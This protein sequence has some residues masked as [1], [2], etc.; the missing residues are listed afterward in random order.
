M[1]QR[2]SSRVS[3]SFTRSTRIFSRLFG[4][5]KPADIEGELAAWEEAIQHSSF[6][7]LP[8]VLTPSRLPSNT[9]IASS[10]ALFFEKPMVLDFASGWANGPVADWYDSHRRKGST[11]IEKLQLRKDLLPPYNHEYIV[12]FTRGGHA[13][14]VDRR[15]DA[16]APFDT[17]M[18][19]GCKTYDMVQMVGSRSL[20]ELQKTSDCVVELHWPGEQTIDLLFVLSVCFALSQDHQA[21]KYTLQRYNCYFLSWTIIMIAVREAAAWETRL[22]PMMAELFLH[23]EWKENFH[24]MR[25]VTRVLERALEW[26]QELEWDLEQERRQAPTRGQT[27]AEAHALVQT[28]ARELVPM[29]LRAPEPDSSKTSWVPLAGSPEQA[30]VQALVLARALGYLQAQELGQEL[31]LAP[32]QEREQELELGQESGQELEP[33]Q[34]RQLEPK[35]VPGPE[36]ELGQELMPGLEPELAQQLEPELAQEPEP[37]PEPELG[38]ERMQEL[39]SELMQEPEPALGQKLVQEPPSPRDFEYPSRLEPARASKYASRQAMKAVRQAVDS[40]L[41]LKLNTPEGED[42][43][44]QGFGLSVT[45]RPLR[46]KLQESMRQG[47]DPMSKLLFPG[48]LEVWQSGILKTLQSRRATTW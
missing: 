8:A 22:D 32:M 26:E 42:S 6:A 24:V 17:I 10:R 43:A 2:R 15:P 20:Q 29:R 5:L 18:K 37:E 4:S 3:P 7:L 35:S 45:L 36:P 1:D 39:E 12:V 16:D 34:V 25:A 11:L 23:D 28:G 44:R 19:A 14:R 40:D 27:F 48:E 31:E 9:L 47:S 41:L 13:Y 21:Q 30:R 33:K 38:Q 46:D